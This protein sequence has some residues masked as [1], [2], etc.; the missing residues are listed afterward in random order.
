MTIYLLIVTHS[1]TIRN[2]SPSEE[3]HLPLFDRMGPSIMMGWMTPDW[4][5]FPS[6]LV[7]NAQPEDKLYLL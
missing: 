6:H 1:S 3:R 2:L 5:H 4:N 7:G